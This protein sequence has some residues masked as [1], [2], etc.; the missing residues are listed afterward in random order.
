MKH[1]KSFQYLKKFQNELKINESKESDLLSEYIRDIFADI[2]DD[3]LLDIEYH[4]SD[5]IIVMSI[6]KN[7]DRKQDDW[8]L[9]DKFDTNIIKN[10][11]QR[12]ISHI[13]NDIDKVDYTYALKRWAITIP[14][15]EIPEGEVCELNVNIRLISKK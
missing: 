13:G 11:I 3:N 8:E 4:C 1:L 9:D 2:L 6:M 10:Y 14:S 12:L 7:I 5:N 15:N